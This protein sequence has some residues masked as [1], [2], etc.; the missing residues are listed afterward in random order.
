MNREI[1]FRAWNKNEKRM[2]YKANAIG[3]NEPEVQAEW[4]FMQYTGLK[5]KNGKECYHKDLCKDDWN[6]CW[7]I[8]WADEYAGFELILVKS[9]IGD[10]F[11]ELNICRVIDMEAIGNV[12]ENPELLGK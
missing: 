1:R 5:D 6:N 9:G 4:E 12:M 2:I 7:V 11:P 10:E 8:E 3:A